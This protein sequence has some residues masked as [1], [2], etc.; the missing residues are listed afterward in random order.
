MWIV[1]ASDLSAA[2]LSMLGNNL[3]RSAARM[4]RRTPE[5]RRRERVLA[6]VNRSLATHRERV[7]RLYPATPVAHLMPSVATGLPA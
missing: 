4:A 1:P 6:A 5:R 7:D 3:T 2:D